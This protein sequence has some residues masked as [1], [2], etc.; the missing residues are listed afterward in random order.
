MT[1]SWCGLCVAFS[2][3]FLV[4]PDQMHAVLVEVI[5]ASVCKAFIEFDFA[6]QIY[7]LSIFKT[8][9]ETWIVY[10]IVYFKHFVWGKQSRTHLK[11]FSQSVNCAWLFTVH[12]LKISMSH[13]T[14]RRFTS[15]PLTTC[16]SFHVRLHFHCILTC[17]RLASE[18]YFNFTGAFIMSTHKLYKQSADEDNEMLLISDLTEDTSMSTS[19]AFILILV[20]FCFF[21]TV[22]RHNWAG[23]SFTAWTIIA[24]LPTPSNI[25]QY[26][27]L[28]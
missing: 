26:D 27:K 21:R 22:K 20:L 10:R 8:W 28:E 13:S 4:S 2:P 25:F 24:C 16:V 23:Y 1:H 14:S 7:Y 3:S 6:K 12:L 19:A 17:Q 11:C 15:W 18:P 9:Q 5:F